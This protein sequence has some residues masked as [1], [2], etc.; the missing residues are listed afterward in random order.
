[1]IEA[2]MSLNAV[3]TFRVVIADSLYTTYTF[4]SAP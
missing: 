1:V 2:Y 4:R 3:D